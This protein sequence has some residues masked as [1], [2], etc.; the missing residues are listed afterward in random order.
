MGTLPASVRLALWATAVWN[1][2]A[3][4][5]ALLDRAF[6]DIDDVAGDLDRLELWPQI[7]E[8]VL[9]CA[10]PHA[11]HAQ[12]MPKGGAELVAEAL[13]AGECTYVP[14]SGGALVPVIEPYGPESDQGWRALLRA[15]DC[16]PTPIHRVEML[17]DS[18]VERRLQAAVAAA[19][20]ELTDIDL[21]PWQRSSERDR[22]A[23]R[24][25]GDFGLP[26][27]LP[28]RLARTI[29]SAATVSEAAE[30][31][32]EHDAIVGAAAHERR[33]SALRDLMIEA[34]QVL[35]DATNLA[36][37]VLAGLVPAR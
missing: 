22:A 5:N 10:L 14:M 21:V 28:A 8:R 35:A 12:S 32:L 11:G 1:G 4:A 7:G 9:L 31:A 6:P 16:A 29:W 34:D 2:A 30:A 37:V 18:G 24:L 25:S 33:Q 36:A 3:P 13:D 23:S 17:T 20:D 19:T 15:F 27:G 26:A